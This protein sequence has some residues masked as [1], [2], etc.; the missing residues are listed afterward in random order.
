MELNKIHLGEA[1]SVLKTFPDQSIDMCVT[2]P[3]Y[4]NLRDYGI[5]GQLGLEKTFQ[6][7]IY[8]L[9]KI[10]DEI[11]RVLKKGGTCWINIADTYSAVGQSGGNDP[12]TPR[13]LRPITYPK[14]AKQSVMRKSMLGIPDR[15]KIK[16]IDNGWC[17]R[18]EIIWNKPNPM[19]TS[20]KDR[21]TVNFD[22]IYPFIKPDLPGNI[23][24]LYFFARNA[25]YFFR[26]QF[27]PHKREYLNRYDYAFNGT[28]GSVIPNEKRTQPRP[29][30]WTPN[31]KGANELTVWTFP[32]E[33]SSEYKHAGCARYPVELPLRAIKA[34]CPEDGIVLDPFM[35]TGTTAIAAIH[36]GVKYIGIE[37]NPVDLK[38]SKGRIEA[39]RGYMKRNGVQASLFE[40]V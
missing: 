21:F 22:K 27:T 29:A 16:M 2:S 6:E 10:I 33:T 9:M 20:A 37:L 23:G 18:N 30:T 38:T 35:G 5:E 25:M 36:L 39:E 17:L 11:Y 12:N 26:Q 34:G 7:Y 28:P 14:Q 13:F 40:E 15:L 19:R 32:T 8:N 3:P 31:P 1:L 24:R 4:W